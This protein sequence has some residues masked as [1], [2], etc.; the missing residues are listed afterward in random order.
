MYRIKYKVFALVLAL[1]MS[2]SL[3]GAA[4]LLDG[5]GSDSVASSGDKNGISLT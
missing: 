3:I 4:F 2:A 1:V 5:T